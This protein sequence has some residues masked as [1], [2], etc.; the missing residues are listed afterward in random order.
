MKETGIIM[1]GS[2]PR[3]ILDGRKTQ[4]RR[5]Y[6]LKEINKNPDRYFHPVIYQSI[7]GEWFAWFSDKESSD[8]VIAKCP[9]GGVGDLLWVKEG[10]ALSADGSKVLY[11][12]DYAVIWRELD[13]GDFIKERGLP[14]PK[15]KWRPSIHMFRKH[16]RIERTIKGLRAER[17]QEI[18]QE[19]A[20]CEGIIPPEHA[21]RMISGGDV[22]AVPSPKEDF[23]ELWDSINKKKYPYDFNPWAFALGF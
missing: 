15:I 17:L 4:T 1:T 10:H 13:L 8:P 22:E 6:G 19:D 23:A 12:A 2:H 5:T 16:S 21:F 18:S 20:V 7:T 3:D 11:R 9:Y 14:M